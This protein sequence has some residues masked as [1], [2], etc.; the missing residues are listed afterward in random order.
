MVTATTLTIRE[1]MTKDLIQVNTADRVSVAIKLMTDNDMGSVVV[2]EQ[3]KPVGILSERDILRK[4][5]PE[6]LCTRGVTVGEVMTKPLIHI[7]ADAGVGQASSLMTL[8]NVRWLLVM[9]KGQIA[10]II[11]QKDVMRGTLETFMSLASI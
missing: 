8:K 4:V 5:C 6:K 7:D 3:G 1:I 10:D 2:A 11:T 9:E